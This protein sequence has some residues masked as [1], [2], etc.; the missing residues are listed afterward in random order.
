M[1]SITFQHKKKGLFSSDLSVIPSL[2]R[3]DS[4]SS[5]M[6]TEGRNTF[7]MQAVVPRDVEPSL[8]VI[9]VV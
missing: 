6:S 3:K 8:A 1:T 5:R 9:E 2:F 7:S 4:I